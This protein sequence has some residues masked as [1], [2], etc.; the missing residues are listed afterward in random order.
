MLVTDAARAGHDLVGQRVIVG[1]PQAGTWVYEQRAATRIHR[2]D[3]EQVLG[4]V[5]EVDWYRRQRDPGYLMVPHP[6]P[7]ERV[8]VE[9]PEY[10]GRKPV[11][12]D[13]SDLLPSRRSRSLV[14]RLDVPP[15]R[16]PRRADRE[17]AVTGARCWIAT[18]DGFRG[19]LRAIGEPRREETGTLNL[20]GGLEGLDK[21]VVA[22]MVPLCVEAD[23]Y[24]WQDTGQ[25]PRQLFL[26]E[27][28]LV[29]LE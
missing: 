11:V 25:R 13:Q 10:S 15:S 28:Q 2:L 12:L 29:Y 21:V 24:R 6:V 23:W 3:G 1:D 27:S 8:F 19:D 14:S 5:A 22:A 16:W 17:G 20:S 18:Q 9:V 4:V 7:V 26:V